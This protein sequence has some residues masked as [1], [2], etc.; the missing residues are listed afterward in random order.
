[1]GYTKGTKSNKGLN[2]MEKV[3]T[4]KNRMNELYK[5]KKAEV[6]AIAKRNHKVMNVN[7]SKDVLVS[8]ILEA[9]FGRKFMKE[10]QQHI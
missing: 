2:Q 6:K 3:T 8:E 1:M 5:M 10:V 9:E 7:E 4:F